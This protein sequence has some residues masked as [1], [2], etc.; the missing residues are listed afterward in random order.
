MPLTYG[1]EV[2]QM[3]K[4][5]TGGNYLDHTYGIQVLISVI[6]TVT[7]TVTSLCNKGRLKGSSLFKPSKLTE[8]PQTEQSIAGK[9][10]KAKVRCNLIDANESIQKKS[11]GVEATEGVK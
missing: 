11:R 5:A 8:S 10:N 4:M 1:P 6:T 3:N 7:I 2:N 9:K